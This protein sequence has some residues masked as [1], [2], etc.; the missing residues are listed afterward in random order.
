MIFL[1][2]IEKRKGDHNSSSLHR[3]NAVQFWKFL[4]YL[5]V[6]CYAFGSL[7]PA[8]V[9]RLADMGSVSTEASLQV[10]MTIQS[11]GSDLVSLS[12]ST[13]DG[14]VDY[15]INILTFIDQ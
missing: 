7:L 8:V 13:N 5:N 2:V 14:W 12:A 3:F 9:S 4:Y 10:S 6:Y 11:T 15:A 1:V